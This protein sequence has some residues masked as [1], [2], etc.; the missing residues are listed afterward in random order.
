VAI[1]VPAPTA[2]ITVASE[3]ISFL[4]LKNVEVMMKS[5]WIVVPSLIVRLTKSV[6]RQ[7]KT[8]NVAS[9]GDG[10]VLPV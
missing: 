4:R 2:D 7:C 1:N 10:Y 8:E 3:V 5:P 9:G 6:L